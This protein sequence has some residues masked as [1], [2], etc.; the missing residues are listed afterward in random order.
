M[1]YAFQIAP[2]PNPYYDDALTR[3]AQKEL[4]AML[5]FEADVR[6]RSIGASRWLTLSCDQPLNEARLMRLASHS[7]L[8]LM[9]ESKDG[10][11]KP[12]EAERD[13]YVSRSLGD[14]PRYKGK[15]GA[16]FTRMMIHMAEAAADVSAVRA[17]LTVLDP[18]CGRGTTL[19][20][21][22]E[23]GMNAVGLDADREDLRQGMLYLEQYMERARYK[24]Q[25]K[26]SSLSCGRIAVPCAAYTLALDKEAL[27]AGNSRSVRFL[28]GDTRLA[29]DVMKKQP[30]DLLVADL[31]YGIQHAPQQG[32]RA[33]GIE[34]LM[35][36]ALPSWAQAIRVGGAMAVSFNTLVLKREK[37][38]EMLEQA[39]LTVLNDLPF[40]AE[41]HRLEQALIRDYVIAKKTA[42]AAAKEERE[43]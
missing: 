34:R 22:L 8:L 37:L 39:G 21:A 31:P 4:L 11:L 13:A 19:L 18:M 33:D 28:N 36:R 3:L 14:I 41:P 29:A 32:Q 17:K 20:C 24:L 27:K 6:V 16:A 23:D 12:I 10:W 35:Q 26:Q 38:I 1:E 9:A 42:K 15:T 5:P 40:D 30:A 43:C 2:H 7:S 25:L